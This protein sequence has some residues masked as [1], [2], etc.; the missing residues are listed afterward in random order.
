MTVKG[1]YKIHWEEFRKQRGCSEFQR[2]PVAYSVRICNKDHVITG[3]TEISPLQKK[4]ESCK[5]QEV[6]VRLRLTRHNS[7]VEIVAL[8]NLG[9]N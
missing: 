1:D 3:G 2:M 8:I 9:M 6:S 7:L 4:R 5:V